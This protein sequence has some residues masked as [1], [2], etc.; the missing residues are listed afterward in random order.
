MAFV[1]DHEMVIVVDVVHATVVGIENDVIVG[2]VTDGGADVVVALARG[3][4]GCGGAVDVVLLVGNTVVEVALLF[5]LV[6]AFESEPS[7]SSTATST[8]TPIPTTRR[9]RAT[10]TRRLP[11]PSAA[12]TWRLVE[13]RQ[14]I[15]PLTGSVSVGT[16]FRFCCS[17]AI[18]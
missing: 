17:R 10:T 1:V 2:V 12:M 15:V 8:P 9:T 6:F 3:V 14:D 18:L 4:E 11:L 16:S 7:E 5:A 13:G